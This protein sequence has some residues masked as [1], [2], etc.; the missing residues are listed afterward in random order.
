MNLPTRLLQAALWLCAFV[1]ITYAAN[2]RAEIDETEIHAP[3][4]VVGQWWRISAENR[5]GQKPRTFVQRVLELRSENYVL[6]VKNETTGLVTTS[7]RSKELNGITNSIDGYQIP[8]MIIETRP[9]DGRFQFP[10]RVGSRW[11]RQYVLS[12]DSNVSLL[13]TVRGRVS[14]AV[15][16]DTAFGRVK[17]YQIEVWS[18]A[19]GSVPEQETCMYL[20]KIGACVEYRAGL[21]IT[22]VIEVGFDK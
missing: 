16:L 14:R 9:N 22:K 2:V 3:T 1:G 11:E 19:D 6:Q 4:R 21:Q 17:A 13:T 10:F 7:L 12:N 20:P 15:E 18:Q 8:S 5:L